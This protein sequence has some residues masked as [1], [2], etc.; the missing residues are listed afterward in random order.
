MFYGHLY[1][2][3]YFE[4]LGIKERALEH[5]KIAAAAR[6]ERD[7]GY[8]HLVARVHLRALTRVERDDLQSEPRVVSK[9]HLSGLDLVLQLPGWFYPSRL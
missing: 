6:F 5:I 1:V 8:M 2:G 9:L 7:G 4:G 3:L